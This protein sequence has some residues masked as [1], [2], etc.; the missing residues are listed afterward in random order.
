M[1]DPNDISPQAF[2]LLADMIGGQALHL[3]NTAAVGRKMEYVAFGNVID[4]DVINELMDLNAIWPSSFDNLDH[5]PLGVTKAGH[6]FV[7]AMAAV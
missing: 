4:R 7:R 1:D 6:A 5:V 2:G 3:T